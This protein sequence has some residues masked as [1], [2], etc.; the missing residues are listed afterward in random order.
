MYPGEAWS[1]LEDFQGL[2]EL[3]PRSE[4]RGLREAYPQWHTVETH[5]EYAFMSMTSFAQTKTL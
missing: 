3:Y 5:Y 2:R 4:F 1:D